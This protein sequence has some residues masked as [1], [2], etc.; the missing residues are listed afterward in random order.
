MMQLEQDLNI[1]I[2]VPTISDIMK[3]MVTNISDKDTIRGMR[4]RESTS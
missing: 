3:N 4:N 1:Y 2:R